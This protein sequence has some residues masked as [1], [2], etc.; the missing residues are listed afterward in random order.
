MKSW[1]ADLWDWRT[2][3]SVCCHTFLLI[4]QYVGF[5][6]LLLLLLIAIGW[7]FGIKPKPLSDTQQACRTLLQHAYEQS[8]VCQAAAPLRPP[9]WEAPMW[10]SQPSQQP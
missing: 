9:Q 7:N 2:C 1:I 8:P 3:L 5:L 10:T 6:P 4:S